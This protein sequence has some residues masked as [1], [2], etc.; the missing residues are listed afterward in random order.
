MERRPVSA[1]CAAERARVCLSPQDNAI[2]EQLETLTN[3][4]TPA[5][6]QLETK[7]FAALLPLL[8][9]HETSRSE[10]PARSRSQRRR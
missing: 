1:E 10:N 9:E 6:L 7:D 5:L 8:A 2:I 4:E 3:G